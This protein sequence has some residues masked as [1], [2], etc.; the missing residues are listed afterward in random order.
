MVLMAHP[1]F[2]C[3]AGGASVVI[4]VPPAPVAVTD[5]TCTAVA[6][7]AACAVPACTDPLK[8]CCGQGL[9]ERFCLE[10]SK[11]RVKRSVITANKLR[12]LCFVSPTSL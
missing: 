9:E 6:P 12:C 1:E 8:I 5:L 4:K 2:P 10:M 3:F 11:S 7:P